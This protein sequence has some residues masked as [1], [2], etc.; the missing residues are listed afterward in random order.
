MGQPHPAAL[1]MAAVT[2]VS[3]YLAPKTYGRDLS[4]GAMS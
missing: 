4:D 1:L 2:A 3:I